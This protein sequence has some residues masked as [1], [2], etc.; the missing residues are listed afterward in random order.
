MNILVRYIQQHEHR[1]TVCTGRPHT[2]LYCSHFCRSWRGGGDTH[3]N[4]LSLHIGNRANK[5]RWSSSARYRRYRSLDQGEEGD[6]TRKCPSP[7]ASSG[8]SGSEGQTEH[9]LEDKTGIWSLQLS[10]HSQLWT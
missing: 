2:Q 9:S 1:L 4:I 5:R 8:H 10:S 7:E 3:T 6:Q